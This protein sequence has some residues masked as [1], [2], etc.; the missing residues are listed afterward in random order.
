LVITLVRERAAPTAAVVVTD[1][2][3]VDADYDNG[4][5]LQGELR[6]WRRDGD[7]AKR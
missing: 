2:A 4:T 7:T 1:P 6:C 3:S 5:E